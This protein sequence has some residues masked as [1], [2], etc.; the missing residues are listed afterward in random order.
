MFDKPRNINPKIMNTIGGFENDEERDSAMT[1]VSGHD[2]AYV[3]NHM[4]WSGTGQNI[5]RRY[6]I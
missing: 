4:E 5:L 1:M 6:L 3:R 2:I